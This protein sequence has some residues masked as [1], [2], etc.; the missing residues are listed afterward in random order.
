MLN[1]KPKN[2]PVVDDA[3]KVLGVLAWRHILMML[4]EKL[5]ELVHI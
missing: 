5:Q 1:A 4:D 3:G 2:Y